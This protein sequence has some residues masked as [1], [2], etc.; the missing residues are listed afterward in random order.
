MK[1]TTSLPQHAYSAKQVR[2]NEA[3]VAAQQNIAMFKLMN[4]AGSAVFTILQKKI[5]NSGSVLIICGKGNNGG[6]GFIVADL[7]LDADLDV[8][9]VLLCEKSAVQGNALLAMNKYLS[10]QG[11]MQIITAIDE[12]KTT[13]VEFTGNFIIDA[14]LGTGF[15]GELAIFFAAV[16]NTINHHSSPVIS[17]DIPSGLAADTGAISS[18]AIK[19]SIT[20]TFIAIK[21][22]LLTGQA[23]NVIGQLYFS[24]LG[25][26]NHFVNKLATNI[27]ILSDHYHP[28]LTPRSP[29]SHKGNIGL[30][31]AIGGGE[32]LPGAIRLASEAAL[33]C[34]AGLV[35]VCCNASNQA[36]VFNGRPELMLAPTTA[37]QLTVHPVLNKAKTVIIGPGLGRTAWA[38][39]LYLAI[40][41]SADKNIIVDADALYFLSLKPSI[42]NN[43]VITPHPKEAAMLL[44][45][46]VQEIEAD[47]FSAVKKLVK[48]YGGVCV[49]KGAG[50]LIADTNHL[51]INTSGDAG[52]ASGGMGDVLSGIIA[53]LTLQL[54]NLV[55]A[56]KLGVYL[57]G[58]AADIIAEKQGQRGMLASDLLQPLHYL[59][60]HLNEHKS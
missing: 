59:I 23:A 58:K 52:M 9:V 2:D 12:F 5:V 7:A 45:C 41:D 29:A 43:R 40:L 54:P 57:H 4:D 19:A 44:G 6:D 10:H 14:I 47:R 17:I 49:L 34:G 26:A 30:V 39:K 21:K 13:L 35:S 24:G 38:E 50:T 1:S 36:L 27:S 8:V 15:K 11:N 28:T 31:L 42:N 33:R 20:V 56:A 53:A 48:K 25:I 60:N 3:I 37:E 22:G 18:V 46:T 55:A 32:G 16:I 51:W